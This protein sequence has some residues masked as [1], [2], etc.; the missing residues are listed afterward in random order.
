MNTLPK[1]STPE[2]DADAEFAHPNVFQRE[3]EEGWSRLTIGARE[4][5]VGM[6]LELA[7]E[8]KGPFVVLY[9]LVGS[10]AD[11]EH[12]R[13]QSPGPLKLDKVEAFMTCFEDFIEQDGRHH[14][15]IISTMGDGQLIFDNHNMIFAYG[16]LERYESILKSWGF[17]EGKVDIP[18][19]HTHHLHEEFDSVET[20]L[21]ESWK[22]KRMPLAP[23]DE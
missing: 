12:G 23:G 15:W 2:T 1:F 9:V 22:W 11:N 17:E 3:D 5:E 20:E 4:G 13:Y 8:L 19:A 6:M 7:K 18:A 10:R 14:V 16:N 21:M